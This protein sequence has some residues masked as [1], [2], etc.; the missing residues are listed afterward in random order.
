MSSRKFILAAL[1]LLAFAPSASAETTLSIGSHRQE[2]GEIVIPVM[3]NTTERIGN[4]EFQVTYE[5]ITGDWQRLFGVLTPVA[6]GVTLGSL[7]EGSLFDSLVGSRL[8]GTD[9]PSAHF[10]KIGIVSS[11]G[12]TGYG[13]VAAVRFNIT[14]NSTNNYTMLTLSY[15]RLN[16]AGTFEPIT[17]FRVQNGNFTIGRAVGDCNGDGSITSADALLALGMA[18]G[19]QPPNLGGCDVDGDGFVRTVD[20]AK[21]LRMALERLGG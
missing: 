21:I 13:S 17:S 5:H 20:A 6:G 18:I 10:I 4:L 3:L 8:I 12:F 7:T 1:F 19:R 15:I 14:G 11:T 16:R 2:S 9:W